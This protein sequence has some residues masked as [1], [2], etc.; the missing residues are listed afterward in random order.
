MGEGHEAFD[1]Q[2]AHSLAHAEIAEDLASMDSTHHLA[3]VEIA[4]DFANMEAVTQEMEHDEPLSEQTSG[5]G[6]APM[7]KYEA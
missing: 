6:P 4:K 2:V 7:E 3:H 5:S 1:A